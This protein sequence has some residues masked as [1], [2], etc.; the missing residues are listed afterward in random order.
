MPGTF[1]D[2]YGNTNKDTIVDAINSKMKSEYGNVRVKLINAKFPLIVQMV[3]NQGEVEYERYTTESPLVDFTN[4]VPKLYDIRVV[5][6]T[7]KNGEYDT[8]NYL[9]GIQPERVSYMPSAQ[10]DEV[11][12]SFDFVYEFTLLD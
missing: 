9:L 11:R 5:Y 8:G 7:N 4:V 3:N 10:L 2:F 6:D 1:T 12:A